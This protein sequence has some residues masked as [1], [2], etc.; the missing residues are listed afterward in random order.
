[1]DRALQLLQLSEVKTLRHLEPF[2]PPSGPH[3][4]KVFCKV[5]L[6][7]TTRYHEWLRIYRNV[8]VLTGDVE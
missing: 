8:E 3:R 1:M 7:R 5:A 6:N 2:R 4:F